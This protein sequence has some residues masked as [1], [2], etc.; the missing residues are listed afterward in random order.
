MFFN[1]SGGSQQLDVIP[2]DLLQHADR[3]FCRGTSRLNPGVSALS[4]H[5]PPSPHITT[6]DSTYYTLT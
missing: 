1:V 2:R 6:H 3:P 4:T 5:P